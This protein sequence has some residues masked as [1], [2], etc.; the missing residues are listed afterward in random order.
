MNE[1]TG[2]P[3]PGVRVQ[4][5]GEYV[6]GISYDTDGDGSYRIAG[7]PAG[8][9]VVCFDVPHSWELQECWDDRPNGGRNWPNLE[10]DLIHVELG[11]VVTGIDATIAIPAPS[12]EDGNGA[13]GNGETLPY[14]GFRTIDSVEVGVLLVLIGLVLL[15]LPRPSRRSAERRERTLGE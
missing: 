7:L 8:D 9:Y 12:D 4:A 13:S 1:T 5:R 6:S 11:E 3:I 14:T 2:D 15:A 10:G